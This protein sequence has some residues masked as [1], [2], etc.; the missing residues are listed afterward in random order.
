MTDQTDYIPI[1][2]EEGVEAV[3]SGAWL[4]RAEIPDFRALIERVQSEAEKRK[5]KV[6]DIE[7]RMVGCRIIKGEC[8]GL[9]VSIGLNLSIYLGTDLPELP[10][11]VFADV[12]DFTGASFMREVDYTG[13]QFARNSIFDRSVFREL[14]WFRNVCFG[15]YA[16]FL[17]ARFHGR[18]IVEEATF[19]G[20]ANFSGCEFG[21]D[22]LFR[23]TQFA[24][25]A[26]F[27]ESKFAK[28][29]EFGDAKIDGLVNFGS[30]EV[31]RD[32]SFNGA[33]FGDEGRLDLTHVRLSPGAHIE[34]TMDGLKNRGRPLLRSEDSQ[35]QAD[36]DSAAVQYTM[37]RDNFR[38]LPTR[39]DE[40]EDL[41]HYRAMDLRRRASD[42][43]WPVRFLDWFFFKSCWGYGVYPLRIVLTVAAVILGFGGIY[44]LGAGQETM[45]GYC[46]T[47][48]DAPSAGES[49]TNAPPSGGGV[50]SEECDTEF[51]P[52]YFSVIT[53]TTI[54]YGDYAPRGWVRWV[55]GAEGFLG[56]F[57]MAVFTVSFARKFI[58]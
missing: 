23:H 1:T 44:Q 52:L 50:E 18:V 27:L 47:P 39:T 12:A 19:A 51:H 45:K 14:A 20:R 2:T 15:Q 8:S 10:A 40:E 17:E 38:A 36:L 21:E 34:L 48:F 29:G 3:V 7:L 54:G 53:F 58:R 25:D 42:W 35:Q 33:Q 5:L 13:V 43:R 57:L 22:V 56:L 32:L 4:Y 28:G 41:C 9:G 46:A 37:L 55:A 30:A 49:H 11:C 6:A 16:S 26:F 24:R 31:E